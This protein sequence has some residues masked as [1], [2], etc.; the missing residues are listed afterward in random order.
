MRVYLVRHGQTSW[1]RLGLAQGTTDVPLDEVGHEQGVQL[2]ERL[3]AVR[4]DAAYSSPLARAR[5]TAGYVLASPGAYGGPAL[6]LLDDLG[7]LCYG[8]WQGLDAATRLTRDAVLEQQW[9]SDPWAVRFPGGE[10]LGDV[11]ARAS[12][13]I[14]HLVTAHAGGTVLVSAHGHFNRVFLLRALGWPRERFWHIEQPNAGC[15]V[16]DVGTPGGLVAPTH[17]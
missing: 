9:R 8:E 1:N 3:R 11:D 16:L 13:V 14:D 10:S 5:D 4:F 17:V 2:A 7:E 15:T 12:R 6:A